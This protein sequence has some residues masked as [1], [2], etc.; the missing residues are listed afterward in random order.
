M[1]ARSPRPNPLSPRSMA[2]PWGL[3]GERLQTLRALAPRR[4]MGEERSDPA[5]G[6]SPPAGEAARRVSPRPVQDFHTGAVST[7]NRLL[8]MAGAP[9]RPTPC[10]IARTCS[11]RA[12]AFGD[13][14]NSHRCSS[15]RRPAAAR[16]P[17]R[18][19][20]SQ[21]SPTVC[22]IRVRAQRARRPTARV[23][24]SRRRMGRDVRARRAATALRREKR[25]VASV[26]DRAWSFR[27]EW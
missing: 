7:R 3:A 27:Q 19:R 14:A 17:I 22:A 23:S 20:W 26:A 2:V 5:G 12:I 21:R 10:T 4:R 15:V 18:D 13:D 24:A 6:S 1:E 25:P 16:G 11:V 8:T 9:D